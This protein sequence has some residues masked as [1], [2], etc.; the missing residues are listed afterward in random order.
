MRICCLLSIV[1]LL[2]ACISTQIEGYTDPEYKDYQAKK[3][4]VFMSGADSFVPEMEKQLVSKFNESFVGAVLAKEILPPTRNYSAA[5]IEK[6]LLKEG[7]DAILFVYPRSDDTSSRYG[8]S[9]ISGRS[10]TS[11]M[12]SVYGNGYSYN[13]YTS[14]SA[15]STPIYYSNREL[16]LVVE[17]ATLKGQNPIWKGIVHSKA[18]GHL[19]VKDGVTAKQI[20]NDVFVR[21]RDAGH[22]KV[23]AK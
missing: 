17:L 14:S 19:Y 4:A 16:S 21:L 1:L 20:A 13:A 7:V 10:S 18:G 11:G 2:S 8:G 23:Q 12:G 3:V 5:E 6:V 22:L 9:M 15:V